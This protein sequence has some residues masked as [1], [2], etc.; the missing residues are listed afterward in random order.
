MSSNHL[1]SYHHRHPLVVPAE[2]IYYYER[3]VSVEEVLKDES[4]QRWKSRERLQLKREEFEVQ[5]YGDDLM[6]Y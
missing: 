1:L 5:Y 2:G 3:Q 4:S 6:V